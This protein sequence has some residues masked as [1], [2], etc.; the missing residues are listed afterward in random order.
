MSASLLARQRLSLEELQSEIE[1]MKHSSVSKEDFDEYWDLALKKL[2]DR[3]N[4]LV[5]ETVGGVYV[6]SLKPSKPLK[7]RLR[8]AIVGWL[9]KFWPLILGIVSTLLAGWLAVYEILRR[10]REFK[11]VSS[12]VDNVL[13]RLQE[14]ARQNDGNIFQSIT[15]LFVFEMDLRDALLADVEPC[16]HE[17]L[18]A[19]VAAAVGTHPSVREGMQELQGDVYRVWEWRATSKSPSSKSTRSDTYSSS[20]S[21][22]PN[23]QDNHRAQELVAYPKV[24]E[25]KAT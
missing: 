4:E 20:T 14:H 9:I 18:W 19:K 15:D 17:R 2:Y 11:I 12:M 8:H 22:E 10:R 24:V 3:T 5:F 25:S 6:R 1:S 21:K 7:C 16:Q 13:E 23:A